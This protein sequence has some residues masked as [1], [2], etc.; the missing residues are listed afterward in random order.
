MK[1]KLYGYKGTKLVARFETSRPFE[2]ACYAFCVL[3]IGYEEDAW[4]YETKVA[5]AWDTT[6]GM[7]VAS[8]RELE[9]FLLEAIH[10]EMRANRNG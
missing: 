10:D 7:F 4:D 1:T 3:M 9:P 5:R 6:D 2:Q 8:K